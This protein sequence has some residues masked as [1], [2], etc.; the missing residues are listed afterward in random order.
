VKKTITKENILLV[1][2]E[3]KFSIQCDHF[4]MGVNKFANSLEC[5]GFLNGQDK[6]IML[7]V[8]GYYHTSPTS[9]EVEG[10]TV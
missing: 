5:D 2:Q 10:K 3:S 6:G 1:C 7:Q 8:P 9:E 4:F